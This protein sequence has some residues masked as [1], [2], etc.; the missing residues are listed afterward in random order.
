MLSEAMMQRLVLQQTQALVPDNTNIP[1]NS[2]SE[3]NVTEQQENSKKMMMLKN[4]PLP[5]LIFF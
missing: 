1:L 5:P 2:T 4:S 3:V